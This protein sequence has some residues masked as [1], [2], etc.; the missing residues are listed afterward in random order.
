LNT[1][2]RTID[3]LGSVS[4]NLGLVCNDIKNVVS[5]DGGSFTC[6]T[7]EVIAAGGTWR[8]LRY[9]VPTSASSVVFNTILAPSVVLPPLWTFCQ[10]PPSSTSLD[11]RSLSNTPLGT[12]PTRR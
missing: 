8:V 6:A 12:T 9:L 1:R 3:Q 10:L 5:D 7:S 11:S 2:R 4:R